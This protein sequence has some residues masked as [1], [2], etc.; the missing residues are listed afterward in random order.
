[1]TRTEQLTCEFGG[2]KCD[3]TSWL[4]SNEHGIKKR[5]SLTNHDFYTISEDQGS[6]SRYPQIGAHLHPRIYKTHFEF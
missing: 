3:C 5:I 2:E 6:R 1:M 4:C